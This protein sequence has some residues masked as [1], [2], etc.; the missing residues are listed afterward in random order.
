M[1]RLLGVAGVAMVLLAACG[2]TDRP[3]GVVERWLVT[4][5][6]GKAGEPQKYATSQVT[7]RVLPGWSSCDTGSLDVIEVGAHATGT[8]GYPAQVLVPYRITYVSDLSS[9]HTT[10][11]PSA[12]LHG[13]A[14][15]LKVRGDWRIVGVEPAGTSSILRVPSEGGK[16]IGSAPFSSWLIA[17][18]VSA[19][20]MLVVSL[21]LRLTPK[22]APLPKEHQPA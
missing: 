1:K 17:L 15:V 7:N 5:N 9:C 10:A 12:P 20:L 22:P 2:G 4:L 8:E 18:I 19:A 21:L 16:P 13:A 14:I 11:K 3:E 6:Q